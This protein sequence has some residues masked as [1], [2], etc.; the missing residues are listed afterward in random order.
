MIEGWIWIFAIVSKK[1]VTET[2]FLLRSISVKE[3][4]EK[5]GVEDGESRRK[6]SK[7]RKLRRKESIK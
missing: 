1:T 2:V 4:I 7:G 5:E 6:E 3:G